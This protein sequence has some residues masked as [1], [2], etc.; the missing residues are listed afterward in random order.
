MSPLVP[1]ATFFADGRLD[2]TAAFVLAGVLGLAFGFWLERAGFSSSRRLTGVFYGRDFAVIQVMFSA[3][4]TALLGL[5]ALV[6]LGLVDPTTVYQ[7]ETFFGPQVVGGLIFGVGFVMGG[8]CPGTALVGL[9]SGKGDAL[10]FL[11]GAA[12]GSLAFAFAWPS[13]A[14]FSTAG[15]W[16]V[17]PARALGFSTGVTTLLV[18]AVAL[19][20]FVVVEIPPRVAPRAGVTEAPMDSTRTSSSALAVPASR[21]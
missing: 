16:R 1:L 10:V 17:H 15:A 2:T 3:I 4:V 7:M 21:S 19:A 12:L 6:T 5:R 18:V 14:S 13:L 20:A 8:W 9:A 11:G